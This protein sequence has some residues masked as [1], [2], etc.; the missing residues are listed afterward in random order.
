MGANPTVDQVE[1][2]REDEQ[3]DQQYGDP[4]QPTLYQPYAAPQELAQK[5]HRRCAD[6]SSQGVVEDEGPPPHPAYASNQG[7]KDAQAGEEACQKYGLSPVPIEERFGTCQPLGADEDVAPPTQ[8]EPAPPFAP[9]PVA[10][11]VPDNGTQDAEHDGIPQVKMSLLDQYS[12]GEEYGL[13]GQ[14]HS[15]ALQH[16]PKEDEQVAVLFDEREDPVH[17]RRD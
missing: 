8:D 1:D 5:D 3:A 6:G 4:S 12:G 7:T 15:R 10:D 11:L 16:H 9:D 14:R 2:Y 17:S 13:T